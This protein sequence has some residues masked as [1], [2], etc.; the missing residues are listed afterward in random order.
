MD[1]T[2][3]LSLTRRSGNYNVNNLKETALVSHRLHLFLLS[4]AECENDSNCQT[5]NGS[6]K[7]EKGFFPFYKKRI[8]IFPVA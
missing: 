5:I 6:V 2:V 7:G 4:R 8:S 3:I 1:I